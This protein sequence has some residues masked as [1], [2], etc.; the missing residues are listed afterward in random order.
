MKWHKPS[1]KMIIYYIIHSYK[2][3][4]N[5]FCSQQTE[6]SKW[7]KTL[8]N[9]HNRIHWRCS[10][11]SSKVCG[12]VIIKITFPDRLANQVVQYMYPLIDR[13]LWKCT[14]ELFV[15]TYEKKKKKKLKNV[16]KF[17]PRESNYRNTNSQNMF[18]VMDIKSQDGSCCFVIIQ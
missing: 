7:H 13:V 18:N 2:I 17:Q 3:R 9:I 4:L 8:E 15:Q 6:K 10:E 12:S 11:I 5:F 14:Q 16:L 1:I